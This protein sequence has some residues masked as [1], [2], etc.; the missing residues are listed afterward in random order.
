MREVQG[1]SLKLETSYVNR[2]WEPVSY[3][4]RDEEW[5]GLHDLLRFYNPYGPLRKIVTYFGPGAAMPLHVGNGQYYDFDYVLRKL[6][7]LS[8]LKTGISKSLFA[9][10]KGHHLFGMFV[11]SLGEMVERVLGTIQYFE[12]MD[13]L[14]F[15]SFKQLREQGFPCLG[16]GDLPLFAPEQYRDPD[17]L[18]EPFTEDSE[19]AWIQGR[20]LISR[21]PVWLPAQLVL[22]FYIPRAGEAK[23]GYSTTG[24]LASHINEREALY[25]GI[26]EL[27]ERDSVNLRWY[28]RIPP[29][30]IEFDRP[31]RLPALA[32]ILSAAGG[33]PGEM[34]FYHHSLDM[35]EIPVVTVI[36]IDEWLNRFAYYSGGGVD[37]D[38]DTCLLD[39]LNEYGQAERNMKLSLAAPEW[40]FARG[41]E[42]L[43]SVDPDEDVSKIDIFFKIVAYY[44]YKPNIEKMQWYL[45]DGRKVPL[46]SLPSVRFRSGKE[47]WNHL[48]SILQKHQIDP[49]IFDFT[50]TQMKYVKLMKTYIPELTPP[51]L[52][53]LPLLGHPRYY[54]VPY[55]M[56]WSDRR[57]TFADLTHDP[58]PY[59]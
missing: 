27:F 57:L 50:P 6:M 34:T 4:L 16:P 38:I 31:P 54:E 56:G 26:T 47:R 12:Q 24:G 51:F 36:E 46:S 25:H 33:L 5:N 9:G 22:L 37:V 53:S 14:V 32:R 17:M 40:G 45:H 10:G 58:M 39:A 21:E 15:G 8:G 19:V 30:I 28:C 11:S 48:I 52:P 41:V 44:G 43:F 13:R 1:L 55:K 7:G 23:I 59:P 18:Y 29:D 2:T 49:V 20:R 35:P 3:R 42:K